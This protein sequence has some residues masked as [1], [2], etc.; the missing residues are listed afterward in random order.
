[1][2]GSV[3]C[4]NCGRP[5]PPGRLACPACGTLVASVPTGS[6]DEPD[7]TA[8]V[9]AAKPESAPDPVAEPE[10]APDPAPRPAADWADEVDPDPEPDALP[11]D[12]KFAADGIASGGIVPGSYLPPSA[13]HRP[14]GVPADGGHDAPTW[15]PPA[16]PAAPAA[17]TAAEPTATPAAVPAAGRPT[18]PGRASILS[19]LPFDAPDEIEGWLVAMGGGAAIL[20]FF[21]PW[22]SSFRDG[23]E[24]Y[25]DSWGLGIGAHLPIFLL[26]VLVTV[27]S[28]LPN[29][30]ASWVRNGVGGMV[31]GGIVFGL[32]W[33]YLEGGG[34]QLGAI[35]AAVGALLLIVGGVIAVAPGRKSRPPDAG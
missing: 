15:A 30:V 32:V 27:L 24:G 16:A 22:R 1:M 21:L 5:V 14:A 33:L 17:P 4:P 31:T 12:E 25:F 10:P 11:M 26:L 18:T 8:T 34:S 23:L 29:R 9:I 28:I 20:G 7:Q 13:I 19:D 35:L 3:P 2:S 6:P